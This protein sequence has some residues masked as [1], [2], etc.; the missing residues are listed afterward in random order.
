MWVWVTRGIVSILAGSPGKDMSVKLKMPWR[1]HEV[2]DAKNNLLRTLQT[3][4]RASIG[5]KACKVY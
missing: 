2:S 4:N 1:L 5:L 3:V